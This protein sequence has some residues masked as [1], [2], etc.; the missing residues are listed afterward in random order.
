MPQVAPPPRPIPHQRRQPPAQWSVPQPPPSRQSAPNRCSPNPLPQ[1]STI[2][3]SEPEVAW[4]LHC[5]ALEICRPAT[6]SVARLRTTV[7][8][9]AGGDGTEFEALL[10]SECSTGQRVLVLPPEINSAGIFVGVGPFG[11]VTSGPVGP[12]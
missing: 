4:A 3:G 6:T 2:G 1:T 9:F 7:P 8:C 11:P 12:S 10:G 5:A